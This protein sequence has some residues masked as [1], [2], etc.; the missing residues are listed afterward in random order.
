M[1]LLLAGEPKPRTVGNGVTRF[2]K[3]IPPTVEWIGG[4]IESPFVVT[5]RPEPYRLDL[6]LWLELPVDLV[7]GQKLVP[8]EAP[9]GA[10][11]EVLR[12]TLR[13]P[14]V[15]P[16][17][18]PGRYRV[19][20]AALAAEV[21]AVVG[22]AA[23]VVV[24]PTPELAALV[25]LMARTIPGLEGDD[26]YLDNVEP[27]AVNRLFEAARIL[28]RVAPWRT[29]SDDQVLRLDIP[30]LGV[31]GACVSIIGQLGE[32]LGLIVFPSLA[33]YETFLAAAER[34][35]PSRKRVDLGTGWL[36]LNFEAGADLPDS[37]R[38]EVTSHGWPV[39][40]PDAYPRPMRVDHDSVLMPVTPRDLRI[41]TACAL[42]LASFFGKYGSRF[43]AEDIDPVCESYFDDEDLEVRF[44][45]PY[46]AHLEFAVNRTSN[47]VRAVPAGGGSPKTGRNEPCPCGSG[48]KFKNCCLKTR[49]GTAVSTGSSSD[50]RVI[51]D[52]F[53]EELL[54]FAKRRFGR[55]WTRCFD[56]FADAEAADTLA[57]FWSLFGFM[58]DDA[59]V[60]EHYVAERGA[61]LDAVNL[62]WFAAQRTAWLSMW[63]VVDVEP[64][65][66]ITLKDLLSLETR[67]V[68][69]ASA[70]QQLVRGDTVLARVADFPE[71]SLMMG[72][73]PRPLSPWL[74]SEVLERARGR[75]RL[76]RAVPTERL[77]DAAFGRYLI[78]RW[79]EMVG[80]MDALRAGRPSLSNMDGHPILLTT[81][82][83]AV[84][85]G[86]SSEVGARL[87][88]IEGVTLDEPGV[89]PLEF[90]FTR[91]CGGSGANEEE[92]IFGQAW[93]TASTL[94]LEANSRERA[95]TLR[96][97]IEAVCGDRIKH[98][99]RE[100]LDPLSAANEPGADELDEEVP[101]EIAGPIIQASKQRHYAD[102]IDHELPALGGLTPR[103]AART[104][105]G[106]AKVDALLKEM[107]HM[108]Q[109][110]AASQRYDFSELRRQLGLD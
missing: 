96:T 84:T 98:R 33:G 71:V 61:R 22:E 54:T 10:V 50:P 52:R 63:E 88:A 68:R 27:E 29:A 7:V 12:E 69:E 62:A 46:E 20:D 6:V 81:D 8:P 108:E 9:E 89:D 65:V 90:V 4:R 80:A 99:L 66:A 39:A 18:R 107:K 101:D 56:H 44:T 83:F 95:D 93:L 38:R 28:Y 77:R 78:K 79:D 97:R 43:E 110:V 64:G 2:G 59:T 25:D 3:R 11:G 19:A 41:L 31:H 35:L 23:H 102:W 92:T 14:L 55:R 5:D 58:V 21:R 48:R 94:K 72:V 73:H 13:S 109:R 26:T 87:E 15:G 53:V 1:S 49:E 36:A 103:A 104:A 34:Q 76:R 47:A 106:R 37:M 30:A 32:S 42:S 45:A 86:A 82:H 105:S 16:P 70:S 74:A 60:G 67:R 17:R 51:E 57:V 40:A 91:R 75:L 85:P 100:H 24:A